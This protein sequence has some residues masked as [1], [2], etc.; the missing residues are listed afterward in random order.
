MK[1]LLTILLIV[2][3]L[4]S[5][6]TKR[7]FNKVISKG[8]E[9]K[10]IDTTTKSLDTVIINTPIDTISLKAKYD[11]I[12]KVVLKDSLIYIDTCYNKKGKKIGRLIDTNLFQNK[13]SKILVY[14]DLVYFKKCLQ[15]PLIYKDSNI[16]ISLQQEDDGN[17][18]FRINYKNTVIKKQKEKSWFTKYILNNWFYIL[19]IGLLILIIVIKK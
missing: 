3:T 1:Y 2:F 16:F 10:W 9:N 12:V 8:I 13:M 19:I 14:N 17:F 4:S 7:R 18:R 11:S 6:L 15:S 5:C